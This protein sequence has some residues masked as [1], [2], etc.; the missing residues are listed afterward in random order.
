[1]RLRDRDVSWRFFVCVAMVGF[2]CSFVSSRAVLAQDK[3]VTHGDYRVINDAVADYLSDH[4]M[5]SVD[6]LHAT[7]SSDHKKLRQLHSAA[8]EADAIQVISPHRHQAFFAE[9]SRQATVLLQDGLSDEEW[10]KP[11]RAFLNA[12]V[13]DYQLMPKVPEG[14]E[15]FTTL[16]RPEIHSDF[17]LG[18]ASEPFNP[19]PLAITDPYWSTVKSDPSEA[20]SIAYISQRY[21]VGVFLKRHVP[22]QKDPET[23]ILWTAGTLLHEM[24]HVR[25]EL[26]VADLLFKHFNFVNTT[27]IRSREEL[28]S[29]DDQ[30]EEMRQFRNAHFGRHCPLPKFLSEVFAYSRSLVYSN[31]FGVAFGDS[32]QSISWRGDRRLLLEA[33]TEFLM[34]LSVE[35]KME[36]LSGVGDNGAMALINDGESVLNRQRFEQ[37]L[38][39]LEDLFQLSLTPIRFTIPD[40]KEAIV[41][42]VSEDDALVGKIAKIYFD[43]AL[44]DPNSK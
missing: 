39:I 24:L 19:D 22:P 21:T 9:L 41:P 25:L 23:F 44:Q 6:E 32:D 13:T 33:A 2:F 16:K 17:I 20:G 11:A 8:V 15:I 30:L 3:I 27:A 14:V 18:D 42:L 7:L 40:S 29:L 35:F 36:P 12:I 37:G 26:A 28:L 1:M 43:F 5:K 31:Y 38:K 4:L 34:K 10:E